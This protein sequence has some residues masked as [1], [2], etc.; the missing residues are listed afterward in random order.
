MNV[1]ELTKPCLLTLTDVRRPFVVSPA[2]RAKYRFG[3]VEAAWILAGLDDLETVARVNGRM[4]DFSDDGKTLWGAY[5][6]R[7]MGQLQHVVSSLKNDRD[8]RQAVLTTWRSPEPGQIVRSKD[9]PC[10]VAWHFTVRDD[11]LELVVFMR[12]NDAW[13][14][15][16]YD[17]LSFTTVQRVLASMLGMKLGHYTLVASNLHLYET[18]WEQAAETV[19]NDAH[20]DL[21]VPDLPDLGHLL[22]SMSVD[23]VIDTFRSVLRG[24]RTCQPLEP[25]RCAALGSMTDQTYAE[26]VRIGS[27]RS[28]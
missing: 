8:T 23:D 2:R 26:L 4:R 3:L 21:N 13:L 19:L 17:T 22:Q 5:G 10:T 20:S 7:V 12:S 9:V 27:R 16:P 28:K 15:L 24:E 6:P 14:G 18:H 11:R 1:L 25:F